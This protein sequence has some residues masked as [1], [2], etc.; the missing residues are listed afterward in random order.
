ME[1]FL[2]PSRLINLDN[3]VKSRLMTLVNKEGFVRQK[4]EEPF[5]PS[6]AVYFI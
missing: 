1:G 4:K 6:N 5:K 3:K 2:K